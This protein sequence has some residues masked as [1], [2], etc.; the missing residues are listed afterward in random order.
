[1]LVDIVAD[2]GLEWIKVSTMGEKR[3]LFELAK[4]GWAGRHDSDDDDGPYSD[5]EGSGEAGSGSSSGE[6]PVLGIVRLA[7]SLRAASDKELRDRP[8]HSCGILQ[9]AAIILASD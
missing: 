7:E 1:M 8:H 3:L 9:R 6:R 4:E 5:T 2:N